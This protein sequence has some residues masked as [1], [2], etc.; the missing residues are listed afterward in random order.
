MIAN[1]RKVGGAVG[2]GV[3]SSFF[4]SRI[5]AS[6]APAETR[7]PKASSSPH[8]APCSPWSPA[9]SSRCAPDS[10]MHLNHVELAIVPVDIFTK[11]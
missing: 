6:G 10:E 9:S 2:A 1:T 8:H 3:M 11:D 5:L 7:F 4:N